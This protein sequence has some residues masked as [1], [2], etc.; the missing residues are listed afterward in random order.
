MDSA[1]Y[2]ACTAMV[3]RNDALDSIASNLANSSTKG[4]RAQQTTFGSVLAGYGQTFN[5]V[6]NDA[7]NS[8]GVTGSSSLDL[9]QGS[10]EH[11]GNDLDVAVDGPGFLKVQ[12]SA[13]TAYTRNGSLKVSVQGQLQ[14]AAGD[15]L[16]G[17]NGPIMLPQGATVSI[18]TDGTILANGAIAGRINVVEL[19][20]NA[21]VQS[22]GGTYYTAPASA[23]VPAVHSQLRQGVLEGSNV[24]P[25]GTVVQLIDAQRSSESMR[26]ALSMIDSEMD[27]T[28]ATDLARVS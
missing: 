3:A 1:F 12:T 17:N 11:T 8:F 14:T 22:L 2:A 25:V 18:A 10:L 9:T 28:A 15:N 6:M 20:A 7:V 21:N 26:H 16:V 24:N 27:K 5:S 13:G 4:F 23:E 19:A